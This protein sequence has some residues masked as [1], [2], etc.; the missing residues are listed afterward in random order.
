MP[1]TLREKQ[2]KFVE[3]V[4]KLID[5]AYSLPDVEL[6]FGETYNAQGV[7]HMRG[8]LHYIRLAIDLN[9]FVAGEYRTD[10]ASYEPLGKFWESIGGSWGGRFSSGDGNHFSIEHEG[11]R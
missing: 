3:M 10:T 5:F 9:L 1:L 4:G 11:R 6:T 2:S 7:G 8:S